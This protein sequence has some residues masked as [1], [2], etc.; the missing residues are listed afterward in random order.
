MLLDGR[1]AMD[2]RLLG[3][4]PV[5]RASGADIT[6][7]AAGRLR[8]EAVWLPSLLAEP[9]IRWREDAPGHLTAAF[10]VAG[11]DGE[12]RLVT[13][14]AGALTALSMERWGN[15]DGGAF[16]CRSFGALVETEGRFQG[17][18]IP[19]R[20]RVGWH[21]DGRGFRD[22]GEFF[23]VTVDQAVYR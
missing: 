18:S 12:L 2:W 6:R 17:Y 4:L 7:S 5:M 21:F 10:P 11:Q 13:D 23:R 14:P 9:E 22:Q 15:P 1:G 16:G 3:W 19:T 20:L 8:A